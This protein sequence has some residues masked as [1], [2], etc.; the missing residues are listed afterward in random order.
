MLIMTSQS[1]IDQKIDKFKKEET[2]DYVNPP[3]VP[4]HMLTVNEFVTS[5]YVKFNTI[6]NSFTNQALKIYE[7]LQN[8]TINMTLPSVKFIYLN[9]HENLHKLNFK[10]DLILEEIKHVQNNMRIMMLISMIIV[11][12]SGILMFFFMYP[13]W[14][15]TLKQNERSTKLLMRIKMKQLKEQINHC[16]KF[17]RFINSSEA[18][19]EERSYD[20]KDE[21]NKDPND[22]IEKSDEKTT[23]KESKKRKAHRKYHNYKGSIISQATCY[24]ILCLIPSVYV[25]CLYIYQFYTEKKAYSHLENYTMLRDELKRCAYLYGLMIEYFRSTLSQDRYFIDTEYDLEIIM[26]DILYEQERIIQYYNEYS[27][28][29]SNDFKN[30]FKKAFQ[31]TMCDDIFET[32][33]AICFSISDGILDKGLYAANIHYL[34]LYRTIIANLAVYRPQGLNFEGYKEFL[35]GDNFIESELKFEKFHRQISKVLRFSLNKSFDDFMNFTK[36]LSIIFASI[37]LLLILILY[38]IFWHSYVNTLRD[39][40]LKTKI[41]LCQIPFNLITKTKEIAYYFFETTQ[42]AMQNYSK[43]PVNWI[44]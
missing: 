12:A 32:N 16:G 9:N 33:E 31:I 17:M 27:K 15:S 20:D 14:R 1:E 24:I 40:L 37:G 39:K 8:E 44:C 19:E 3:E 4:K 23:L 36:L 25:V 26:D 41:A 6:I 10:S 7:I 35:N 18:D 42:E 22:E 2:K 21:S 13:I 11:I 34:S 28:H 38:F 29:F 5:S 43:S 30:V